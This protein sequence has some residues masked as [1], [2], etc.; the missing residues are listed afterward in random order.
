MA[1]AR[2]LND[3]AELL[4]EG[5]WASS[6]SFSTSDLKKKKKEVIDVVSM[7]KAFALVHKRVNGAIFRR[8]LHELQV[9][10]RRTGASLLLDS[11]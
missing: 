11:D 8:L 6:S 7:I 4:E 5:K 10:A 2:A 1:S 9:E 3:L